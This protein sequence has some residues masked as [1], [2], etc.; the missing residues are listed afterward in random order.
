[1]VLQLDAKVTIFQTIQWFQLV[2]VRWESLML[3][4]WVR[5]NYIICFRFLLWKFGFN[6]ECELGLGI[7]G[8]LSL[9]LIRLTNEDDADCIG[10]EVGL[11]TTGGSSLGCS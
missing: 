2:G 9:V 10:E 11:P 8:D 7:D 6:W 4:V 3:K 5:R 1:M